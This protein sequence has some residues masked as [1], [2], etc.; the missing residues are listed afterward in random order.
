MVLQKATIQRFQSTFSFNTC[1]TTLDY[2]RPTNGYYN[3]YVNNQTFFHKLS[4]ENT[5]L[6]RV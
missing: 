4:E 2:F 1:Q 6:N 5:Y 3:L